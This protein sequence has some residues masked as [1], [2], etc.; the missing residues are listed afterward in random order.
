MGRSS[1]RRVESGSAR[2]TVALRIAL[3]ARDGISIGNPC[4]DLVIWGYPQS[5]RGARI[6]GER[7]AGM[8]GEQVCLAF[9]RLWLHAYCC[10]NDLQWKE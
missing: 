9:K 6:E 3:R 7:I 8:P 2:E 10:R 4:D 1:T 5:D